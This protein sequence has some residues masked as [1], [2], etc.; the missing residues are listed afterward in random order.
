MSLDTSVEFTD[1]V[2]GTAGLTTGQQDISGGVGAKVGNV[3][4][5]TIFLDTAG[6]VDVTVEFSPDGG[7]N[8]YEPAGE[9]PVQFSSAGTDLVHVEYNVD[10]VRLTGS[11]TTGV[12]AQL[13]EV[14]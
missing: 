5:V 14:V 8:W 11:D 9:S 3:D 10:R 1:R 13:R 2:G 4:S 12:K 7:T 6:A